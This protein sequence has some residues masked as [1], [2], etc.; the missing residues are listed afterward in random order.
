MFQSG[1][2]E[3]VLFADASNAFNLLNRKPALVNIQKISPPLA[4]I[5]IN[6]DRLKVPLSID[7][8]ILHSAE[9]T[10][11]GDILA[12]MMYAIAIL[13]LN[14]YLNTFS[15][16]QVCYADD[17][18]ARG[19]LQHLHHWWK[20]LMAA[21]NDYGFFTNPSKSWLFIKPN[22]LVTAKS[23]FA[24]TKINITSNSCRYLDSP[25]GSDEFVSEFMCNIVSWSTNWKI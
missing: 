12:M 7:G 20:E 1:E 21:S 15:V 9:G 22:L 8:E 4:K 3:A 11:Q 2:F 10:T 17:A 25:I 13:P 5:P 18:A 24:D 23:L 14:H 16:S 6:C 19:K